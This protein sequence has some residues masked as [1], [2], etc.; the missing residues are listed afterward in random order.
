VSLMGEVRNAGKHV[1][2]IYMSMTRRAEGGH[3]YI[4][5]KY[6]QTVDDPGCGWTPDA[7]C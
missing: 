2:V 5:V 3:P 4:Y 7:S 6:N 1:V